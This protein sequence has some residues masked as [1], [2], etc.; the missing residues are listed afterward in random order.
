MTLSRRCRA[1]LDLLPVSVQ[2]AFLLVHLQR[3]DNILR[4]SQNKQDLL[5][6]GSKERELFTLTMV[7]LCGRDIFSGSSVE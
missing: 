4:N 1:L 3:R 7:C 6:N 5:K 2:G